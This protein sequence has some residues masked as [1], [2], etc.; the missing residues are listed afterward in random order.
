MSDCALDRMSARLA[1]SLAPPLSLEP[2]NPPARPRPRTPAR[3]LSLSLA[4]IH[5]PA[6]SHT[7]SPARPPAP[8]CPLVRPNAPPSRILARWQIFPIAR[9]RSV[10]SWRDGCELAAA[11]GGKPRGLRAT[12]TRWLRR[13]LRGRGM[14]RRVSCWAN[15]WPVVA[16]A[17]NLL[18]GLE[19]ALATA[20]H[21]R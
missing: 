21:I 5:R 16:V 11:A 12:G 10:A 7:R 6:R 4:R 17:S 20:R 18:A 15:A 19:Q 13:C 2:T 3:P 1:C 9:A 8:P 14:P